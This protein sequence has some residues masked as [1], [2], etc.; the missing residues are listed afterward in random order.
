M[1]VT[2]AL[3]VGGAEKVVVNLATGL[4]RS[5]FESSVCC[6]Q[7][8]GPL[9][10]PLTEAGIPVTLAGPAPKPHGYLAPWRLRQIVARVK[11]D[12]VHTHG[13]AALLQ[14]GL[15]RLA[16][17]LPAWFHTFHF[18]NYPHLRPR[19]MFAERIMS[20]LPDKLIA[21]SESQRESIIRYLGVRPERIIVLRN[22]VQDM[23]PSVAG[24]RDQTRKEFGFGPDDIVVGTVAV[25]SE[26]KGVTFLLD[27]AAKLA[28]TNPRLRFLIVG[29]GP[30]E[31]AMR[32]RAVALGLGHNAVITGW[33]ADVAELLGAFDIYVMASLWE[34]MP[35][36]LLEAMAAAKPIVVTNVAD[37]GRI[38]ED[39]RSGLLI[40]PGRSEEIF[41]A[42][43][44]IANDDGLARA[45]AAGARRRFEEQFTVSRMVATHEQ[46]YGTV[47]T[48]LKSQI[49]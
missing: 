8:L 5:R 45:L 43:S 24:S 6:T 48:G 37:N 28:E 27:A 17:Q 23:R 22:G 15:L 41:A 39:G 34:A 49:L 19:Y 38:V 2:A 47:K 16:G 35:L 11:P 20:R 40:A 3:Y 4:D 44:R 1:Q 30:Q 32:Q 46:L 29:G 14:A 13:L 42:V 26:Q 9:A 25:L 7:G 12:V 36:A 21:V 10:Q 18:G 33:R 31:N